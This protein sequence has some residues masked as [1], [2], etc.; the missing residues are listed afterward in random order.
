MTYYSE[1]LYPGT[2]VLLAVA[3]VSGIMGLVFL[4]FS[5]TA[6][7]VAFL[8]LAIAA[9]ALVWFVS[10]RIKIAKS[11]T[12]PSGIQLFCNRAHIDLAHLGEVN[13]LDEE[14]VRTKLPEWSTGQHFTLYSPWVKTAVEIKNIDDA[15]PIESWI[16]YT[17]QPDRLMSVLRKHTPSR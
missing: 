8:V 3:A 9:P 5:Q 16:L 1:K 17:R 2:G 6:A 4:P 10:P 11:G 14:A 15:D 7:L 13:D 12:G